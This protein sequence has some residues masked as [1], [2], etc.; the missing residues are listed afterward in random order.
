MLKDES[1]GN[2]IENFKT[3][4][5]EVYKMLMLVKGFYIIFIKLKEVLF[6]RFSEF[7][8]ARIG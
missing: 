8:C 6:L 2:A 1:N 3:Y 7:E 5:N 4:D